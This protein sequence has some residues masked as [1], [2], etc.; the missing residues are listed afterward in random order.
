MLW[1]FFVLLFLNTD[2]SCAMPQFYIVKPDPDLF[3]QM[4]VWI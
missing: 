2:C 4:S 1:T 3:I